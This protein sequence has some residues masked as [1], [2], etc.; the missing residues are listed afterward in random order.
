M[1]KR[2]WALAAAAI[3]PFCIFILV[4]GLNS[5][6]SMKA[7]KGEKR[8]IRRIGVVLIMNI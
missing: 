6:A 2:I 3:I 8:P 4:I 5:D 1:M 7:I